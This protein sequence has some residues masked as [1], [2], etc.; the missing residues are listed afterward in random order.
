MHVDGGVTQQVFLVP[1]AF[2][3][4]DFDRATGRRET[5]RLY[6]LR[7]G[8]ITPEWQSIDEKAL[9]LAGR[10][11][12]TLIKN[13]GIGDLYRLHATTQRDGID[14]NLATIPSSFNLKSDEPFDLS[15]MRALYEVGNRLGRGGFRWAKAPPGLMADAR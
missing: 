1:A 8:K 6:I 4:R 13:Q 9:S 14:F 12:S 11:I 7:N 10:S 2:T 5:R 3:F 15:Y